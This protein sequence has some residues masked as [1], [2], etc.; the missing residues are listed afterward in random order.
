MK[1]II[2]NWKGKQPDYKLKDIKISINAIV[3]LCSGHNGEI[4]F[5]V[6]NG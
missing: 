6:I 4:G 3:I 5:E 1:Y 2:A